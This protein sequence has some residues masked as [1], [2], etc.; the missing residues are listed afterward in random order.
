MHSKKVECFLHRQW[1]QDRIEN[2]IHLFPII[3]SF[4]SLYSVSKCQVKPENLLTTVKKQ[5]EE[6]H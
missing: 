2:A 6:T 3:P 4:P 1:F 5:I